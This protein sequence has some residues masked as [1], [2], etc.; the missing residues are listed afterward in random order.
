MSGLVAVT[1]ATG[2]IGVPL[3]EALQR[4]GHPVR[5]LSRQAQPARPGIEWVRGDLG[6]PGALANLVA[7]AELVFHAG[8]QLHGAPDTV[9]RSFVDGTRNVLDAA[10]NARVVL[11]SSLVVLDTGSPASPF[12]IDEDAPLE[13]SP[14]H[15]GSYTRAK[16]AAEAMARSAAMSQD[17]VIVRPGLVVSGDHQ[18]MPASLGVT[19]GPLVCYVGP[20]SGFL[21]VV[22]ADDVATG[23]ILAAEHL[24]RGGVLHLIDPRAVTR[25]ELHRRLAAGHRRIQVPSGSAAQAVAKLVV[26]A[27][28]AGMRNAAYRLLAAG[29]PHRW[30]ADR[31]TAMGWRPVELSSWLSR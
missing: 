18:P 9:E 1:G 7:G 15:R 26:R 25:A 14:G 6:D 17:V 30:S 31:A 3:V 10:R 19:L 2:R 22:H 24:N 11:V 13:A 21:P 4:A 12:T 20:R 29:R 23:L 5:A 27:G 28:S 8:G 16:S